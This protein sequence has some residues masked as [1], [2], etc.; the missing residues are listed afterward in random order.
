M[1]IGTFSQLNFCD[2]AFQIIDNDK[3][4]IKQLEVVLDVAISIILDVDEQNGTII[5]FY[6]YLYEEIRTLEKAPGAADYS[7]FR[8]EIEQDISLSLGIVRDGHSAIEIDDFSQLNFCDVAFQII[9]N[10]KTNVKRLQEVLDM[11]E[12][13]KKY[14]SRNN[15]TIYIFCEYLYEE[16]RRAE[17][18]PKAA[19]YSHFR[20]EIEQDIARELMIKRPNS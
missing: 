11:A 7:H 12:I 14:A 5:F 1:K 17:K 6:E 10:N 3:T 19:D 13:I 8:K 18:N 4:N 15:G 2:V 9:D 20:K 16:V